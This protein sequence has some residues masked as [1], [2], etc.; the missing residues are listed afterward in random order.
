MSAFNF[1]VGKNLKTTV[2]LSSNI[3]L[4]AGLCC[5]ND[6]QQNREESILIYCCCHK[7]NRDWLHIWSYMLCIGSSVVDVNF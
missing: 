7:M 3:L 5:D 2:C 1:L 4:P 6:R